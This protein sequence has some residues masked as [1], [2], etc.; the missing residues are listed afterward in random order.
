MGIKRITVVFHFQYTCH[1]SYENVDQEGL[2]TRALE[3]FW[4]NLRKT[5]GIKYFPNTT[6]VILIGQS[7]GRI[8]DLEYCL[9]LRDLWIAECCVVLYLYHNEISR[10]ENL[11]G[12][13]LHL[14]WLNN[15]LIKNIRGNL[16]VEMK[17]GFNLV[18]QFLLVELESVGNNH[19][20]EALSNKLYIV[21]TAHLQNEKGFK[22]ILN[23]TQP[24]Q[25]YDADHNH[26]VT[27]EGIRGLRKLFFSFIWKLLKKCRED[28]N[29]LHEHTP[30]SLD[31]I[32]NPWHEFL[33]YISDCST[34]INI[35]DITSNTFNRSQQKKELQ[36]ISLEAKSPL[37]ARYFRAVELVHVDQFRNGS[38][39][40]QNNNLMSFSGFIFLSNA[41]VLCLNYS[42]IE[43][44]ILPG[45]RLQNQWDAEF[46]ENLPLM[47]QSLGDFHL[48]C[49]GIINMAQLISRL[50]NLKT[51]VLWGNYISQTEGLE[52]FQFPQELV[53]DC[54]CIKRISR[55]FLA[56]Q[57]GLLTLPLQQNQI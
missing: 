2:K 4:D 25:E 30:I 40:L 5:A 10:I 13:K 23:M 34:S 46:G 42:H 56:R 15:R 11:E 9:L 47:M 54:N 26:V 38:L 52:G 22:Q 51:L 43:S 36:K 53:L 19:F 45:Q 35:A 24:N 1:V 7:I 49:N 8:S 17:K 55:G 12:P 3:M 44:I 18:A 20:E 33:A 50:K 39:N 29:I 21:G 28:I 57:N 27:L 16:Q 48:G 6:T 32:H 14:L 41:K 31:I 37:A